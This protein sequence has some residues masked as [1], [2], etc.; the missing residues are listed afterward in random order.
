MIQSINLKIPE[1]VK[2]I[3]LAGHYKLIQDEIDEAIKGVLESGN[4]VLGN[5]VASFE[6]ELAHYLGCKHVVSCANGTDA[7]YLALRALDIGHGDE[8][9]TVSHSFFATTGSILLSGATPVFVDIRESDFNIDPLKIEEQITKKTKAIIPVH[10]YG[11]PCDMTEIM[12]LAKK[13]NLY[14]IED[15]AQAIGAKHKGKIAGT[16]GDLGTFSFFPTKNLGAFGDGG[17]VCTNDDKLAE[18]L[19]KIRVHGSPGRYVH[20]VLGINSR[21]DEIQAAILKVELR[22]LDKWNTKRQAAAKY[23]SEQLSKIP[24]LILPVCLDGN[25]HVFHQY[26]I[27]H[28]KRD[29]IQ[30]ELKKLNIESIIYYPIPIHKQKALEKI[31]F[32]KGSLH[33]TEKICN[34][35]LSVPIYPS[36]SQDIQDHVA[37]N[38]KSIL[39]P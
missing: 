38:I 4:Y 19:R 15:T 3:D 6:Q 11:N 31:N 16:F 33:V 29:R 34:E 8:V 13:H 27:R 26:T 23:Y 1:R 24:E 9:I 5:N 28:S 30:E 25:E 20:E 12:K 35:V 37:K 22:Y 14:V 36:I 17:A 21:L 10:L 32:K 7:L 2:I 39:N 18:N